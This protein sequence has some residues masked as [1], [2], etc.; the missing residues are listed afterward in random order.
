VP[1]STLD[2][3][4]VSAFGTK[5]T[6]EIENVGVRKERMNG[7]AA[8]AER[9]LK[10]MRFVSLHH[11]S[12]FSSLDG[13]QLPE[14]HARRAAELNM[15]AIAMT[16]HGNISSHVKLEKACR[17][18]K[19]DHKR[20][21][22]AYGMKPIFGCELY[23][24]RVGKDATQK[25]YHLTVIAKTQ[26]GYRNLLR[27]V[28]ESYSEGFYHEPT[29]SWDM[30][31][32]YR[33]G[34]VV[35][36]GCQGSLLFCSV[37][38]GKLIDE[39]DASYRRGLEVAR[40]FK[41]VFG[42]N[43]FVEVQAFPE[44]DKTR[45]ANPILTKIARKLGIGLVATMDCH[46]TVPTEQEIQKVLHNVRPGERRTLEDMEREWG[47]TV[48]L[49]PP[50]TDRSLY[51][52]LRKTGISKQA[53]YEAIV[54]TELIAQECN[55]VLPKLPDL[56][57][58]VPHGFKDS[59]EYW[60]HLLK[61]GWKFRGYHK[62]SMAD[63]KRAKAMLKNEMETIEGKNFVDYLLVV[64]DGIVFAKDYRGSDFPTGIPVGPARGS[65]AASIACY[66]LRITE[67][68][69]VL[70]PELVF[71]RFIDMSRAD[72]PDI[73]TDFASEGRHLVRQFYVEKYGEECVNNIG[74]F[75]YYKSRLALD[76][77]A[78]VH[79]IPKW[80]IEKVKELL[81]ERSSGDLRASA[82]IEDTIEQFEAAAEVAKEFP[83]I[84]QATQ[85]EGNVKQFGVHAAGLVVSNGDIREVCAVYERVVNKQLYQVV[86]MDKYDA[87]RQGL[88]KLDF[89]G[90]S[91]LDI[92]AECMRL[93]DLPLGDLYQIP[94]NDEKTA[95]GFMAN[96]VVGIFQ[97]EGR[98]ARSVNG[99]LRA[100]SFKEVCDVG[101]LCRPGPLHNGASN[102]YIDI[103]RGI[104][105][106]E[107]IHPALEDI[108]RT[109][110]Y[111]I[112][113]QEQILRIVR[114]IGNFDWTAASHI[115]R[116][117]SKKHGQAEFNREW[118]RY[119]TGAK[120]LHIRTEYPPMDEETAR[121][122]WGWCITAGSYAFNVAHAISYGML[123]WWMMWFK[124][125]HT[126]AFYAASLSKRGDGTGIMGSGQKTASTSKINTG[127]HATIIRDA[128]RGLEGLRDPINVKPPHPQRSDIT[129]TRTGKHVIRAG[130]AQIDGIGE[131]KARDIV[132]YRK[133]AVKEAEGLW[134]TRHDPEEFQNWDDLIKIKGF[135]EKTV[136][137]IK[138][139]VTQDDPFGVTTLDTLIQ[140]IKASIEDGELDLPYPTHNSQEVPYER[141]KDVQVVWVGMVLNRN[142]RDL[143]ETNRARHG[144]ELD[145]K[146][147]RDPDLREWVIMG[148]YDG[149]EILSL[150]IDRF[151]YPRFR[152]LVWDIKLGEDIV[153]AKG[154]KP[155]N[156]TARVI[157]LSKLWVIKT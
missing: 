156:R 64:R 121:K 56:C 99:A 147:V 16:E 40:A 31:R 21:N 102:E 140:D 5:G 124:M 44:L 51:S 81:V 78:K 144:V 149:E 60:R 128:M 101:A 77:V 9:S 93:I 106:P 63:V 151:R 59:Q 74:T 80:E 20:P 154:V 141:G 134:V 23:T 62:M 7:A 72:P 57:Y 111:Q 34:L 29:V 14:V 55:V 152:S 67:V 3:D 107:L 157:D 145:P 119:W 43:Y 76:D 68:N 2:K 35:L 46:Y 98:A 58:P 50:K 94:L 66:L 90:L 82:T 153:V 19:D 70:F 112:V 114:T 79:K 125:H 97:L 118:E 88:L 155:G 103:K 127:R 32:K 113:Y 139:W 84:H 87:E 86:S 91:T 117:I 120:S 109:T 47:Y 131:N 54:N 38:G 105:K 41:R 18:E 136:A 123:A 129:W 142:L 89:L 96:D 15:S 39:Q 25:K 1:I 13:F 71:E 37:V 104:S 116:I 135:G 8:R 92:I 61:E 45:R 11:H 110:H 33:K 133:G 48:P 150:R 27:L 4:K 26:E 28:S 10:P 108:T 49:C 130:F 42:D 100:E 6:H 22:P 85:L 75:T 83:A 95:K 146:D 73:D 69:P 138:D 65:A 126:A 132:E 36:S 12:T 30:L 53:A 143:F 17:D 148:G 52:R 122:I 24:G 115:R 137:K